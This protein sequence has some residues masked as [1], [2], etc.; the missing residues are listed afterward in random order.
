MQRKGQRRI[1]PLCSNDLWR[2]WWPFGAAD[3]DGVNVTALWRATP[4]ASP[5]A[6]KPARDTFPHWIGVPQIEESRRVKRLQ[7]AILGALLAVVLA[8]CH[9]VPTP[10]RPTLSAQHSGTAARLQAVSAVDSSVAW[11]SGVDGTWTRTLDGGRSWE[12]GS[13][14]GADSLQFRDVYAVSA[15]TAYLLSAGTGDQSRIY[16]TTDGGA[17]WTLEFVNPIADAFFDCFAFWEPTAGIAFSDA[18]DGRFVAVRTEDGDQWT[19]LP[20]GALPAAQT[21]EGGFAASGTCVVTLGDSTVW[22]ATGNAPVARVLRSEDRGRTWSAAAVPVVAGAAAGLTSVA[23]RDPLHGVAVG[24]EIG[25]DGTG[26]RRVART[27]DGGRSWE[28]GGEPA[29]P[30][31]VYGAAYP[32]ASASNALVAVGPGG[33]ALSR[34]DGRTWSALDSLDY[35]SLGFANEVTGWLVGP[36]GRIT[37]VRFPR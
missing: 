4:S 12:V 14:A 20:A 35:W 5:S 16:R 24:G 6:A 9:G 21:G 26:G 17:N 18:V 13:V 33:A 27:E 29:F 15:D 34:D 1:N 28:A 36:D 11:A 32:P 7:P 3:R 2:I 30:G 23:F 8:A 31:A 22:I 10:S 19:P 25:G 37:R